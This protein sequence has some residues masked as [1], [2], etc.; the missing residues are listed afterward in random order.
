MRHNDTRARGPVRGGG[1]A[2]VGWTFGVE[3]GSAQ[4]VADG[5]QH[6]WQPIDMLAVQGVSDVEDYWKAAF[7]DAFGTGFTPAPDSCPGTPYALAPR[8]RSAVIG[9]NRGVLLPSLRQS[10]SEMAV[11]MVLAHEYCDSVQHQAE[12]NHPDMPTLV[13]EQQADCFAGPICAG[14]PQGIHAASRCPPA[15]QQMHG[16]E[17]GAMR[18]PAVQQVLSHQHPTSAHC[19][20]LTI[21][22]HRHQQD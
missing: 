22:R 2:S 15:P 14:S 16:Y 8:H 6:R 21:P 3:V 7:G 13:A 4:A 9:W 11:A 12:L 17:P 20:W 1:H 10:Y 5:D 19:A 18:N